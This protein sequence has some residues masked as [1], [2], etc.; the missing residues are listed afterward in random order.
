MPA[1]KV[2]ITTD[3]NII[4]TVTQGDL[5]SL[6][7][8]FTAKAPESRNSYLAKTHCVIYCQWLILCEHFFGTEGAKMLAP[9]AIKIKTSCY[10]V[11]CEY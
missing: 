1:A 10:L 8:V 3:T 4:T 5:P 9:F 6:M 11:F 2:S 7:N